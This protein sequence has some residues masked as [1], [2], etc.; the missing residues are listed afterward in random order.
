MPKRTE[1]GS[2]ETIHEPIM[3]ASSAAVRLLQE[4]VGGCGGDACNQNKP[5]ADELPAEVF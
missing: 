3:F 4:S 5:V 1:K 2:I